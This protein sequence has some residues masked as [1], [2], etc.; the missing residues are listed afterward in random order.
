ML[1]SSVNMKIIFR[2]SLELVDD[3]ISNDNIQSANN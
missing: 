3:R 2:F 1:Q